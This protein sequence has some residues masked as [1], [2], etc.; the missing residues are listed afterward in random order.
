MLKLG[1]HQVNSSP[2][3]GYSIILH[4]CRVWY[5]D[6]LRYG[7]RY[8]ALVQHA[9]PGSDLRSSTYLLPSSTCNSSRN[10]TRMFGT[11]TVIPVQYLYVWTKRYVH[12]STTPGVSHPVQ[13]STEPTFTCMNILAEQTQR[14][15]CLRSTMC[16]MFQN[17][18]SAYVSLHVHRTFES[19]TGSTDHSTS[20]CYARS[21]EFFEIWSDRPRDHVQI[22]LSLLKVKAALQTRLHRASIAK[23]SSTAR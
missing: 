14:T 2:I 7:T 11:N 15:M 20:I 1:I 19:S 12:I 8:L 6:K 4:V 18:V 22:L 10:G 23:P 13:W 16:F 9:S 21:F 5:T 17:S 3:R